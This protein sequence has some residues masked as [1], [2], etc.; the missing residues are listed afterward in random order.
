VGLGVVPVEGRHLVDAA[1]D[2]GEQLGRAPLGERFVLLLGR[3][4]LGDA[5][6]GILT[7]EPI[8]EH[9]PR[10]VIRLVVGGEQLLQVLVAALVVLAGGLGVALFAGLVA[11]VEFLLRLA[12]EVIRPAAPPVPAPAGQHRQ[13]D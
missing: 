4:F 7:Q 6:E 11:A 10:D 5:Q 1:P 9:E 2:Q 3:L 8:P 13:H 12:D